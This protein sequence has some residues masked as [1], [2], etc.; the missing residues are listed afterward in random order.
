MTSEVQEESLLRRSIVAKE[1]EFAENCFASSQ[2]KKTR[3]RQDTP[4]RVKEQDPPF[5]E[6]QNSILFAILSILVYPVSI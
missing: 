6:V 1:D 4:S 3:H 5:C 2:V